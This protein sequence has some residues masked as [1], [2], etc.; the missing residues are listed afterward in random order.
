MR[1]IEQTKTNVSIDDSN[2]FDKK[3][4]HFFNKMQALELKLLEKNPN[5]S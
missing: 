5:S 1:F 4:H 3:V 2:L